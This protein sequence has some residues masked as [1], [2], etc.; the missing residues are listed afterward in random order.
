MANTKFVKEVTEQFMKSPRTTLKGN[1]IPGEIIGVLSQ[2]ADVF[3][4]LAVCVERTTLSSKGAGAF[5]NTKNLAIRGYRNFAEFNMNAR[6]DVETFING[7]SDD[8]QNK[9]KNKDNIVCICIQPDKKILKDEAEQIVTGK[10]YILPFNDAVRSEY[11]DNKAIYLIVMFADSIQKAPTGKK[12]TKTKADIHDEMIRKQQLKIKKL[13]KLT[14]SLDKARKGLQLQ[15]DIVAGQL[16]DYD[17]QRAKLNQLFGGDVQAGLSRMDN[18]TAQYIS[19]LNAA[20]AS[21]SAKDR[22]LA[23]TFINF[24]GKGQGKKAA[25]ILKDIEDDTLRDLLVQGQPVTVKNEFESMKAKL[26]KKRKQTL[27]KIYALIDKSQA[28]GLNSKQRSVIRWQVGKLNNDLRTLDAQIEAY[29]VGKTS[30]KWAT[31]KA[32]IMAKLTLEIEKNINKGMKAKA[33]IEKATAKINAPEDVKQD[34]KAQIVSQ[35][36]DGT[37]IQYAAQQAVQDNLDD[38]TDIDDLL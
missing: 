22:S 2:R 33:A 37:P 14:N 30:G 8:D 29:N 9:F 28:P 4:K 6:E 31:K 32:D 16:S 20:L 15:R 21:A 38:V 1:G 10:S 25:F 24:Q 18:I 13:N 36:I 23:E 19:S 5:R 34:I 12:K 3:A 35:V 11:K 7:L 17:K 26:V 27:E